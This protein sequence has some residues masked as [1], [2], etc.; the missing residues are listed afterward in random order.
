VAS[1]LIA[2]TGA[3]GAVGRRVA[4]LLAAR[5]KRLRLLVRDPDRAPRL[6]AETRRI[7]GYG[8]RGDMRAA[9]EGVETLFL[10]PAHESA[11]RVD[12]HIAAVD[13]AVEAGVRRIVYLSFVAA[14]PDSTFTLGRDHWATEERIR[15]SGVAWIFPRMN[16]YADFLPKMVSPAGVIEGPADDGR[17]AFVARADVADVSAALIAEAGHEGQAVDVTGPEAL[18][19]AEV[20]ERMSRLTGKRIT[21]RD[22][23]LEEAYLSR[24]SYGAP[25]W[26]VTAWVS[27]YTAIAAGDLTHGSEAVPR[28]AGHPATSLEEVLRAQP[29]ALDHVQ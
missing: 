27:T 24:A 29:H 2:V 17:A 22:Q 25:D 10:V 8:A 14:R 26:Q 4:E 23:T 18:T 19:L 12:Q 1:G 11:D 5:G 13:T 21:F 3:T 6:A 9:L 15:A 16:L 20:A 28:L 7:E